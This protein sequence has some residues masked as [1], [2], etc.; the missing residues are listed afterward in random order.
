M[1]T[2]ERCRK[3][4]D[5]GVRG[6]MAVAGQS[7]SM[8]PAGWRVWWLAIRPRTLPAAVGPIAIGTAVAIH[9][10]GFYFPA[11]VA[12]LAVALLLQIA[13]NLANDLFDFKRGADIARV[14]PVRVT[15]SGFVT[16]RAMYGATAI[17]LALA[18]LAGLVLIQRGG[19]P[20]FALGVIALVSAVSYTA[21]PFPLGYHG[22]GDIFVFIFF[23]LVGVAGSAYVQTRELTWFALV[24]AVPAG[25]LVTAIIV[26]NNLRDIE[27]DRA[28]NKRTLAVR[29]GRNGT[30]GEYTALIS[31]AYVTPLSLWLNGNLSLWWWFSWLSLPL[32]WPLLRRIRSD[33]GRV[34]NPVLAG[35]AKLSLVYSILFAGSI[36]L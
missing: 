36:L 15:Q 7:Q 16:T 20:I 1:T 3:R 23:G 8:P 14:G 28:A 21:G 29:I 25:A 4:E 9:E 12:A 13:A 2:L 10:D 5:G 24:C 11:A 30:I 34:L 27:T 18:V 19:W 33:R 31:L 17:V 26:V 32:A 35:T 22:L 6:E